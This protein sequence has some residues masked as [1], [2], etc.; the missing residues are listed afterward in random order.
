MRRF[1]KSIPVLGPKKMFLKSVAVEE[2]S[3]A[4]GKN[5]NF[6]NKRF[7][8]TARPSPNVMWSLNF[9]S[10][11]ST[12]THWSAGRSKTSRGSL[13]RGFNRRHG[14]SSRLVPVMEP[15]KRVTEKPGRTPLAA[16]SAAKVGE[17]FEATMP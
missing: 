15:S 6:L 8:C 17:T 16:H 7:R 11:P 1:K 9:H 2:K 10:P 5:Y 14:S 3:E 12:S 13:L 4:L